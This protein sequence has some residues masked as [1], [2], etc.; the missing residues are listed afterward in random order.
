MKGAAWKRPSIF[1]ELAGGERA[2]G[3]PLVDE[4]AT[5]GHSLTCAWDRLDSS[6]CKGQNKKTKRPLHHG[7]NH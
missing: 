1:I 4:A 3:R 7:P 2:R 5:A 6:G